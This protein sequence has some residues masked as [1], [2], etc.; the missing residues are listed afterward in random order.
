[1][2]TE[3]KEFW[4]E[5]KAFRESN[6]PEQWFRCRE[7]SKFDKLDILDIDYVLVSADVPVPE[8]KIIGRLKDAIFT[9]S[10]DVDARTTVLL[11]LAKSAN[12]LPAIFGK[13]EIK[14]RKQRIERVVN[15]DMAGKATKEAIDAMQAAVMVACIMPMIMMSTMNTVNR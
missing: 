7:V 9:E 8:Q 15:G 12:I 2:K 3:K 4:I 6:L 1:M 5:K 11:S 14:Q 10:D 13:R